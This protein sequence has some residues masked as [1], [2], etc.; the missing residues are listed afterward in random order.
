MIKPLHKIAAALA[1]ALVVLAGAVPAT[2]GPVKP[3]AT[4]NGC[5]PNNVC[6]YDWTGTNYASG[7]WQRTF[8]QIANSNDGA[9][10]CINLSNHQWH[11]L[12]GSPNNT[13]SSLIINMASGTSPKKIT[14]YDSASCGGTYYYGYFVSTGSTRIES[15]M[16]STSRPE[17]NFGYCTLSWYDRVSSVSVS[18]A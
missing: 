14:F 15:N 8:T 6:L 4:I 9:P 18:N 11:D 13:A 2:A 16:A 12:N 1:G 10:D 17:C 3:L 5:D 7:F